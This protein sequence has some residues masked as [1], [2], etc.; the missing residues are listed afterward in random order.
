M[1]PAP[2][3]NTFLRAPAI[4]TPMTSEFVYTLKDPWESESYISCASFSLL[5]A[6]TTSVGMFMSISF[7]K[8][9]PERTEYLS[10]P[11]NISL[12]ASEMNYSDSTNIPFEQDTKGVSKLMCSLCSRSIGIVCWVGMHD[13]MNVAFFT[14]SLKL[15]EAVIFAFNSISVKNFG[16]LLF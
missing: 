11:E 9:G 7:A 2:I 14:V 1:I 15:F 10:Y 12:T 16:F 6:S 13:N 8:L 4:S 5:D 3:A